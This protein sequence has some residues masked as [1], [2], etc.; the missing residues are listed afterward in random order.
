MQKEPC[1]ITISL[2][3]FEYRK[4]ICWA[5]AHGKPAAT[6]AGQ[7][8]GARIEANISTIDEMMRD[9]AKFEGIGVEDLEQQWLD[10]DKKGEI[11]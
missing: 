1:R 10:F 4:L 6:Y 3:A 11:E 9:I 7:I 5:K 2:S 8:I